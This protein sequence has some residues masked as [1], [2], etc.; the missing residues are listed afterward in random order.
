MPNEKNNAI[1]KNMP[2]T[3]NDS[4]LILF[5]NLISLKFRKNK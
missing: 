3:G 1:N 2:L 5:I 4:F